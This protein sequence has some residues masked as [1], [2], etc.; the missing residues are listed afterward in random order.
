LIAR[1][2]ERVRRQLESTLRDT[3]YADFVGRNGGRDKINAAVESV[4]NR[5]VDP[6]SAVEA[7]LK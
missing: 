4:M 7:L 1:Q 2:R 6:Y 3:L 5:V